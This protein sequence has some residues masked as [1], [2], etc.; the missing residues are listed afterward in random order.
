MKAPHIG[1]LDRLVKIRLWTDTASAAF[2]INQTFDAGQEVWARLEP[3][4]AA[5][6]YGTAQV[7][8]RVTHRLAT[9]R[10]ST[11]N[12]R[13]ITGAHVVECDEIRY[14]VKRATNMDLAGAFTL[15][16]LEELELINV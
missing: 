14:R 4:G 7:E 12:A 2:G 5:L 9:W 10:T 1:E 16:D 15:L 3:T 13:S 11:V 8:S 6:F